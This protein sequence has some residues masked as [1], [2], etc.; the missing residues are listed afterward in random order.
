DPRPIDH[1]VGG[2]VS[3][4]P[5]PVPRRSASEI[6]VTE[7]RNALRCPRVFALGRAQG[8]AVVFPVGASSLGALFHRIAEVF[9][10]ELETP[11]ES[12]RRLP[13]DA[14]S[15]EVARAISAWLLHHL[16]AQLEA[17]PSAASMP[18]EIDDLA[19]AL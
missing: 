5:Q 8:R 11:P 4:R 9:A 14:P 16:V 6:S 1:R 2:H 15:A 17:E 3:R 12:V 7:V 13:A 18:G 10:R 19:E